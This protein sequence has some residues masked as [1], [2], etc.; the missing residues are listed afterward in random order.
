VASLLPNQDRPALLWTLDLDS[1]GATTAI[2]VERAHVRSRA[3]LDY[4]GV[5]RDADAGTLPDSIAL[6]PELGELLIARGLARGAIN[7]PSP[8][9]QVTADGDGWRLDLREPL[10]S[11]EHNAQISLATGMA[12][13]QLMLAGGIGLLRTMPP[14]PPEAIRRLQQAAKSLDITWP[15]GATPGQVVARV[16]VGDPR[17]AAFVD[18]TAETLRGAGYT[19]FNGSPPELSTHAG[20]AAAYAHAT[21]PLRRL[22]D[23]YTGEACLALAAGQPVPDWVTDA[24]PKLP[25]VMSSTDRIA[26]GAARAAVDL[27]EA[28]I[29][30]GRVG[31]EFEAAVVDVDDPPDA[32]G[33]HIAVDDPAVRARCDGTT[34]PLGERVA[35]KL[36]VADPVRRLVRFS[37][38]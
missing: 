7:L 11:E 27:A 15:A 37:Y 28:V 17:G 34:L 26:S 38:P 8:E 21:A 24:L 29:L 18:Q 20:V 12:A 9:Q 5:Q 23:R 35:V 1:D 2:R 6:L 13:A 14:P 19:A 33:G 30:V 16:S 32:K 22:A 36:T 10:R 31:E 4:V 25:E 3:K